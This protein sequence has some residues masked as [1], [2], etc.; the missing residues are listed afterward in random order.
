[1]KYELFLLLLA[2]LSVIENAQGQSTSISTT[3]D[4]LASTEVFPKPGEWPSIRRMETLE[5]H[6]P[7]KG[8]ITNPEI[9]W[10]QFVGALESHIVV[11]PGNGQ[12]EMKLPE[13]EARSADPIA[14]E[15][16]IPKFAEED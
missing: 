8:N 2:T 13:D 15:T 9:A 4:Q 3:R 1:M 6:S 5:A 14:I 12:V 10:K 16:F 11:E 7:L